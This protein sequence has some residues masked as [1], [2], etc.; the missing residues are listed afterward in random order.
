MRQYALPQASGIRSS[1]V[2]PT[3]EAKNFELN[4]ALITFMEQDQF[5][6]HPSN[7][8]NV[9]LRKFLAKCDTV[10]INGVTTDAI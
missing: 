1:I 6:G 2:N 3:I 10:K 9:H 7:N 5:S 4:P 8:P